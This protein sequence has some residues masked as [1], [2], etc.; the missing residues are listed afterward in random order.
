MSC[1]VKIV[2]VVWGVASVC[3]A[4]TIYEANFAGVSGSYSDTTY[5]D[6]NFTATVAQSS[7]LDSS[8]L[9][10]VGEGA[11]A[12]LTTDTISTSFGDLSLSFTTAANLTDTFTLNSIIVDETA[13]D[14]SVDIGFLPGAGYD[15]NERIN[16]LYVLDG[17]S[18]TWVD[19]TDEVAGVTIGTQQTYSTTIASV[20]EPTGV[21]L[22]QLGLFSL[23]FHRK[24]RVHT[25]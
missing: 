9:T 13:T 15:A 18:S 3:S 1:V 5:S 22:I 21:A 8:G 24:R 20:P 17:V 12:T 23:L 11:T 14:L 25:A 6:L 4:V 2:S 19:I 16:F 10:R 7:Y